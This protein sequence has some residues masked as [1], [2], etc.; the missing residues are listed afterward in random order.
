METTKIIFLLNKL[1]VASFFMPSLKKEVI[2]KPELV[3]NSFLSIG[4]YEYL[5]NR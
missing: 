2:H 3:T 1:L 4:F 5:L